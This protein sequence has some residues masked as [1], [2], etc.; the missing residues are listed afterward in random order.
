MS[1]ADAAR[2]LKASHRLR[3]RASQARDVKQW[4][5]NYPG[6]TPVYVVKDLGEVVET[7]TRSIA[8]MAGD[9]HA[10]VLVDGISGGYILA[11]VVPQT[12]V[13]PP[14]PPAPDNGPPWRKDTW[15]MAGCA[16]P[17][18][19]KA[20]E[21]CDRHWT[22]CNERMQWLMDVV[23]DADMF[24][25]PAIGKRVRTQDNRITANPIFVVQQRKRYYG[26]DNADQIA[27]MDDDWNQVDDTRVA[28][29][30]EAFEFAGECPKGFTRVGYQDRWEY[31]MPFFTEAAAQRYLEE[32][33]HNLKEPRIYVESGYR[34]REWEA[35]RKFLASL[36]APEGG[37][38]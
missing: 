27:W 13:P 15:R 23:V 29:L 2:V 26:I 31:V 14:P 18:D 38:K 22:R 20:K 8:W 21:R 19:A 12:P 10:M 7:R 35:I 3:S 9:A 34:N 24:S 11:R 28:E 1:P 33:A 37:A 16:C 36:P 32:N 4:N 25:L 17:M 6:G 30:E 5:E